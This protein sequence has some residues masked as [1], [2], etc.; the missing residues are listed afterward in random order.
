MGLFKSKIYFE[1][2]GFFLHEQMRSKLFI[3]IFYFLVIVSL[4]LL[5]INYAIDNVINYSHV[6]IIF[7]SIYAYIFYKLNYLEYAYFSLLFS[8]NIVFI[9]LGIIE[10]NILIYDYLFLILILSILIGETLFTIILFLIDIAALIIGII[11]KAFYYADG[12][13]EFIP[14]LMF[15][16]LIALIIQKII[17]NTLYKAEEYLKTQKL[18]QENLIEEEKWK[19]LRSIAGG[20]GHDLNN[21]LMSIVGTLDLIKSEF[22]L[23]NEM[24]EIIYETEKATDNAKNLAKQL[25]NV[26]KGLTPAYVKI[27][28]LD[29]LIKSIVDFILRGSNVQAV[30]EFQDNLWEI[31]IDETHFSQIIQNIVINAKEAM[32]KGGT[33][34]IRVSNITFTENKKCMIGTLKKG[35]YVK[36]EIK[37]HGTGIPEEIL[38]HIFNIFYTSKQN[39]SGLG[40]YIVKIIMLSYQGAIDVKTKINQSTTFTLYFQR[41]T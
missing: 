38:P 35:D 3:I 18:M 36:I 40:L 33:I 37:D 11:L 25:L 17:K 10:Q 16:F 24:K 14:Q 9:F 27:K 13:N 8:L 12:Y 29:K 6:L 21:Y 26:A 7:F 23:D 1:D 2:D 39:G 4:F 20:I 32:P 31:N 15:T 19:N 5:I 28:K 30:Y 41:K 34:K 22:E